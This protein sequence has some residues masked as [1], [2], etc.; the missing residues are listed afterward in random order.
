MFI[1]ELFLPKYI[2]FDLD[3]YMGFPTSPNTY[4]WYN[5]LGEIDRDMG[6][7]QIMKQKFDDQIYTTEIWYQNGKQHRSDGPAIITYYENGN[8]YRETW[9]NHE[10]INR[11][12]R[13]A[14]IYYYE[15]GNKSKELWIK[16]NRVHR[17]DGP[18]EIHYYENGDIK[19]TTWWRNGLL[20]RQKKR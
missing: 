13:P 9:L 15:N 5:L 18:A 3:N 8:K 17:I 7:A 16:N 11:I 12:N 20:S 6:P 2:L 10:I 1:L 14:Q 4:I 19:S